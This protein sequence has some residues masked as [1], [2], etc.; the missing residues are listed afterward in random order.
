LCSTDREDQ[1]P[2][3]GFVIVAHSQ[4]TVITADLLQ[5]L[6]LDPDPALTRLQENRLIHLFTMGSPLRQL[7]G[8]GFPHLYHWVINDTAKAP[9]T[10]DLMPTLKPLPGALL[11][12]KTWTNAFRSGDYVGRYLWRHDKMPNQWN[13]LD[14]KEKIT[15]LSSDHQKIEQVTRS[16]FCLGAGAHTHYWDSTAPEVAEMID[17]LIRRV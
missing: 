7:Y 16:E 4:G 10:M 13:R 17:D 15:Y 6:K 9:E 1:Q 8:F 12:V 11:G 3:D 2:Y 5:F 14:L